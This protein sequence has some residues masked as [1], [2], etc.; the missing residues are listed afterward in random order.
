[1]I[2]IIRVKLCIRSRKVIM[3]YTNKYETCKI[4]GDYDR[5]EDHKCA[6]KMYFRH[7]DWGEEWNEIYAY[8]MKDAA[9]RFA[10]MYNEDGDY[11]LMN[12]T[13]EVIIRDGTVEKVF[14]IS[15]EPSIEYYAEEKEKE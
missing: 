2:K 14:K 4:C 7:P 10:V 9:K 12:D 1:M 8:D 13:E 5:I 11:S 3:S 6:P 15:A